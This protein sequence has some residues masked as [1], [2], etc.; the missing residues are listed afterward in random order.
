MA[1][2]NTCW[3]SCSSPS[4]KELHGQAIQNGETEK[5]LNCSP[6]FLLVIFFPF[7][8]ILRRNCLCVL[9][10]KTI[11]RFEHT[12]KGEWCDVATGRSRKQC[13]QMARLFSLYSTHFQQRKF[14]QTP[15]F[16]AKEG[17]KFGQILQNPKKFA[18]DLKI[19]QKWKFLPKSG[20]NGREE[21]CQVFFKQYHSDES[22]ENKTSQQS[23]ILNR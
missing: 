2:F 20:H 16:L 10:V 12:I 9:W 6:T 5:P 7:W 8:N 11:T 15:K 18:K 13:D 21:G 3:S 17:L 19:F 14:A 1:S 22:L 4:T 23:Q